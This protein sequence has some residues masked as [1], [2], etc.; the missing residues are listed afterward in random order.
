MSVRAVPFI[1]TF[2]HGGCVIAQR[3][4]AAVQTAAGGDW[5]RLSIKAAA[6]SREGRDRDPL[7]RG[8]NDL[9]DRYLVL[10][11]ETRALAAEIRRFEPWGDFDP[12]AAA[13]L[14]AAG[15]EV[16]LFKASPGAPLPDGGGAPG[17]DMAQRVTDYVSGMTDRY[18]IRVFED[19]SVPDAFAL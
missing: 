9:A 17:A 10:R 15:R 11:E 3:A 18:C 6:A 8:I 7:V 19:L 12:A 1:V 2:R 16:A 13:R 5:R 14:T 4:V